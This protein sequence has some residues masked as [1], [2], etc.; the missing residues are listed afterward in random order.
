MVP[1]TPVYSWYVL[2]LLLGAYTFNWMD[3]YVLVILIEPI[4]QDL[5]LSDTV[6]G[7]ITGFAFATIYSVAG[8]SI[9]RLG[10]RRSRRSIVALGLTGWSAIAISAGFAPDQPQL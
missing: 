2:S 7:L 3:R 9:A 6:L 1:P 8:I 10:D 4:K 5:H